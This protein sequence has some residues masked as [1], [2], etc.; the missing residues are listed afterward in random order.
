MSF[1]L[2]TDPGLPCFTA[3]FRLISDPNMGCS[4]QLK[5]EEELCHTL[6]GNRKIRQ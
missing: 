1:K 2:G 3:D 4:H 5:L 6:K